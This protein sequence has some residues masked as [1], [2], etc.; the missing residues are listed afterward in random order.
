MIP[1]SPPACTIRWDT[2]ERLELRGSGPVR[3][4][5]G[6]A[7]IPLLDPVPRA[8]SLRH[9]WMTRDDEVI[10]EAPLKRGAGGSRRW[11][12]DSIRQRHEPL[13]PSRPAGRDRPGDDAGAARRLPD[14]H[15]SRRQ[16][17]APAG[18]S[19]RP[20]RA[21]PHSTTFR[22]AVHAAGESSPGAS[23]SIRQ[24]LA[25]ADP[26]GSPGCRGS[27][28]CGAGCTPGARDRAAGCVPSHGVAAPGPSPEA[29]AAR[30]CPT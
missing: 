22:E 24:P 9:S 23:T 2:R 16:R 3:R 14:G 28:S 10:R 21:A 25:P 4:P 29:R 19:H 17:A 20:R 1:R 27:I 6:S 12:R 18:R 5:H 7:R 26:R 13:F 30:A 8:S 11:P 15:R